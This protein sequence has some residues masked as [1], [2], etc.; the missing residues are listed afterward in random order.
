M[1][2]R[3]KRF[4]NYPLAT[5]TFIQ[6]LRDYN[7]DALN[8]DLSQ[9]FSGHMKTLDTDKKITKSLL[10]N[11]DKIPSRFKRN[12]LRD[13]GRLNL[14]KGSENDM[15]ARL[16]I[17]MAMYVS[18]DDVDLNPPP[19]FPL[20]TKFRIEYTGLYCK[21]SQGDWGWF[22]GSDEPYAVIN[23]VHINIDADVGEMNVVTTTSHPVSDTSEH[24]NNV[25]D[26]TV[27]KG[28]VAAIWEGELNGVSLLSTLMEHDS[29]NIQEIKKGIELIVK[30]VAW[31]LSVW[32][33]PIP[34]T[35]QDW[36]S[37]LLNWLMPTGDD[38]LGEATYFITPEWM[39][40]FAAYPEDPIYSGT[41]LPYHFTTVHNKDGNYV[42]TYRV[43][44]DK[45]PVGPG[46]ILSPPVLSVIT[47]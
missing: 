33:Y 5:A 8:S 45:A 41:D 27:K 7:E 10:N 3:I 25:D 22:G 17:P 13:I 29:D 36:I 39:R 14:T 26:G 18:D 9:A 30:G 19:E 28:P 40:R 37:D 43:K 2:R 47:N 23:A 15:R 20:D 21:D 38:L 32:G 34:P 46:V 12:V 44:A 31:I 1:A 6:L 16:T 42:L 24:Y 35:V 4:A 11:F